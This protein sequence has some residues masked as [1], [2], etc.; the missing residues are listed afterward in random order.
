MTKV[1]FRKF[2][3]GDVI[4]LFPDDVADNRGHISSYQQQGQHGAASPALMDELTP[5]TVE[6][7]QHLLNELTHQIG[8]TDLRVH[9]END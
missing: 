2:P 1:V 5:A 6:E 7:Y 9:D 3:E 4:A 8:Y